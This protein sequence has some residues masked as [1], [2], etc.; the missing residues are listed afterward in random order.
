MKLAKLSAQGPV[1]VERIDVE[2]VKLLS[3]V[4]GALAGM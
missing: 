4:R 3:R 1:E 2:I